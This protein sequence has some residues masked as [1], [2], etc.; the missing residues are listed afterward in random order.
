MSSRELILE[1]SFLREE[2]GGEQHEKIQGKRKR[3]L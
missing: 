2:A 1:I 3:A